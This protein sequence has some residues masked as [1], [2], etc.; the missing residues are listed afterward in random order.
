MSEK[1]RY[2]GR[3]DYLGEEWVGCGHCCV[4]VPE[5]MWM[6]KSSVLEVIRLWLNT[7]VRFGPDGNYYPRRRFA[8]ATELEDFLSERLK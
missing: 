6:P 1:C 8:T 3:G 5:D 7:E 4:L 2:C